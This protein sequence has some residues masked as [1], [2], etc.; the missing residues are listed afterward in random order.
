MMLSDQGQ[1]LNLV[2]TEKPLHNRKFA[3][4]AIKE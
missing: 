2:D 4:L 3:I 1:R